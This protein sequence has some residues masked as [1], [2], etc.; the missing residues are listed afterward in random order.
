M[1]VPYYIINMPTIHG[2]SSV[3]VR[4]QQKRYNLA[5]M[6]SFRVSPPEQF[7]FLQP[8]SWPKWIR[9]FERF[10][11]ASGLHSKGEES[12]VNMLIYTMG[13]KADDIL[14]SFG[15]SEDDQKKYS[16]VK[17]KFESEATQCHI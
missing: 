9:R 3:L 15:L 16:V 1:R 4:S 2:V 5:L 6:A 12:Q 8:D 10:R 14:S 7:D 11:Q 17:D 13:D